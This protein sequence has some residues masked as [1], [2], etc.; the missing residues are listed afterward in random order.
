MVLDC[1]ATIWTSRISYKVLL[2]LYLYLIAQCSYAPIYF[3]TN[4][5]ERLDAPYA[6]IDDDR[7]H[8]VECFAAGQSQLD[9]SLSDQREPLALLHH[10]TFD[11]NYSHRVLFAP[12]CGTRSR[13]RDSIHDYSVSV[14]FIFNSK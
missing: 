9:L 3:I 13:W 11:I 12:V 5:Y 14:D 10:I 1:G 6:L 7:Y 2:L 8:V 4:Y